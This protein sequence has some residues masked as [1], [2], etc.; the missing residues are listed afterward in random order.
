MRGATGTTQS[1][2]F[3]LLP[4]LNSDRKWKQTNK[5]S[6][7]PRPAVQ[8]QVG[9]HPKMTSLG[10]LLSKVDA[11]GQPQAPR[12][13]GHP[14]SC[15]NS[16]GLPL[17]RPPPPLGTRPGWNLGPD[18]ERGMGPLK[19]GPPCAG[20]PASRPHGPGVLPVCSPQASTLRTIPRVTTADRRVSCAGP[21][22]GG[23]VPKTRTAG[24]PPTRPPIQ[25]RWPR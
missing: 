6:I 13:Q 21:R 2:P 17:S 18:E 7:S 12:A 10:A 5:N 8:T 20:T 23:T 4:N 11:P 16:E 22:V 19:L 24:A 25:G 9:K 3:H 1:W 14:R 15:A